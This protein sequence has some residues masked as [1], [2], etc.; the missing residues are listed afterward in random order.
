M[1]SHND[2]KTIALLDSDSAG[3]KAA[4][5][6]TVI[7]AL[8]T[9]N[10]LRTKDFLSR[11]IQNSEIEDIIR[12]TLSKIFQKIFDTQID[13]NDVS[14]NKAIIDIFKNADS[15]FSKF[16]LSK[17]FLNWARE[18][19]SKDLSEEEVKNC[20]KLIETINRRLK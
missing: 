9:K 6:D 10:I 19:S 20:E 1:L 7:N 11:E 14:S 16:K 18:N 3:D 15:Q 17:A 4:Q 8:G 13:V 5:Q 2:L 12:E